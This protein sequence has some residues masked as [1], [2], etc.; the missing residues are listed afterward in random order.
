MLVVYIAGGFYIY[1]EVD[2]FIWQ[3]LDFI[4]LI[5]LVPGVIAFVKTSLRQASEKVIDE[6]DTIVIKIRKLVKIYDRDSRFV[7]EWKSG[8]KIR[9]RAGLTKDYKHWRVV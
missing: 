2:Q 8:I 3:L 7:R 1:F 4:L 9:E 6:N 5:I